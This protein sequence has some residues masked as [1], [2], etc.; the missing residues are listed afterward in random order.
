MDQDAGLEVWRGCVN[1]WECDELG[2][3]NVRFYLTRALDGLAGLAAALGQPR[4]FAP[5]ATATL[6]T[7]RQHVRFLREAM[8]GAPLYMT[9]GLLE[10]HEEGASVL[11][12]LRHRDGEP[13]A[14]VISS[15]LHATPLGRAFPWP[16]RARDAAADLTVSSPSFA[17]PRNFTGQEPIK[18]QDGWA[19]GLTPISLAPVQMRDCDVFGY[20][21]PDT[22]MGRISDGMNALTAPL[23]QQLARLRTGT[24]P[25]HRGARISDRPHRTSPHR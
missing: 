1:A 7:A 17:A 13:C 21:T 22:V 23:Y 19:E 25:E 2:H 8:A 12:I 9:A 14:T 4:A 5:E 18:A 3:M 24:A 20:M 11:Q 10:M 16:A 6:Q 15:L